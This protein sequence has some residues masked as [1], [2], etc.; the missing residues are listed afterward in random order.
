MQQNCSYFVAATAVFDGADAQ[1]M[2][3]IT[4][5]SPDGPDHTL[6]GEFRMHYCFD[7][8]RPSNSRYCASK[9]SQN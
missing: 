2:Y 4:R 3:E 7:P 1:A 5:Y 8:M 6:T 9:V